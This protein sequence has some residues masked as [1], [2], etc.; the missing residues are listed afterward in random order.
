[1]TPGVLYGSTP[2]F[3]L[4]PRLGVWALQGFPSS[5]AMDAKVLGQCVP[6]EPRTID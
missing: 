6:A 2:F 4:S 1:M 5:A 3:F